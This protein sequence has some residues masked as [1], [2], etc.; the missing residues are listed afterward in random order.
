M[1][2]GYSLRKSADLIGDIHYVTLFYWR[3][4]VLFAL[5]HMDFETFSGIV[6]MDET[7]FLYSE[8][9]KR[10]LN[11]R[12]PRKLE[13]LQNFEVLVTNKFVS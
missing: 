10:N 5:K 4:K 11:G 9:G 6:E 3:H 8:K 1:L 12:K 2:E 7:Y 13:V